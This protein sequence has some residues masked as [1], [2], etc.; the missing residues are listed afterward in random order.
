MLPAMTEMR[1]GKIR[2]HRDFDLESVQVTVKG[3]LRASDH[4]DILRRPHL[5]VLRPPVSGGIAKMP[6]AFSPIFFLEFCKNAKKIGWYLRIEG[7]GYRRIEAY[8]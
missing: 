6:A 5:E 7:E 2:Q 4:K 1:V 3:R 8:F